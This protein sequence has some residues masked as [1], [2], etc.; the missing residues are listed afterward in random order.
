MLALPLLRPR[1]ALGCL[2]LLLL[3]PGLAA[4]VPAQDRAAERLLL[5]AERLEK[6]GD[7][8]AALGELKCERF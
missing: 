3:W 4:P 8:S 5:E 2:L 6:A 7:A 1:R